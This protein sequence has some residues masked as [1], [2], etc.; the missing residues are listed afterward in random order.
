MLEALSNCL[1]VIYGYMLYTLHSGDLFKFRLG[2]YNLHHIMD[3]CII[4]TCVD[5]TGTKPTDKEVKGPK[6]KVGTIGAVVLQFHTDS[7]CDWKLAAMG[8]VDSVFSIMR[9]RIEMEKPGLH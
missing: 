4:D 1:Q 2:R 6:T 3:K 7:S 9:P 8:R 5:D